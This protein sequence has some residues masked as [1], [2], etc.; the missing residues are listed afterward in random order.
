MPRPRPT[1]GFSLIELMIS[2]A[3]VVVLG[4]IA[5]PSYRNYVIRSHRGD[6]TQGLLRIAGAQEKFYI[7]NNTYAS[8]LGDGG[9]EFDAESENGWYVFD[10]TSGDV[11][12]FTAEAVP[13]EGSGQTEDAECQRFEIDAQQTKRAF[14]SEGSPNEDVCWR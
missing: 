11:N 6:A 8:A 2:L 13:A 7:S 5:I 4:S 3:I 9:L 10:V 1:G 14:D 12:G